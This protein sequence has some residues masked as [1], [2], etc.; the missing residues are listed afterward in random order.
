MFERISNM[1]NSEL[2]IFAI[3][4][5]IAL[6]MIGLLLLNIISNFSNSTWYCTKMH[7]H[8][9]PKS[10]AFDGC[11]MNGKCPRCGKEV[12]CDSQGNWF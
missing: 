12:M 8:K 10:I 7:W 9:R 2:V 5:L 1:S 6:S 3:V 11:S 4:S